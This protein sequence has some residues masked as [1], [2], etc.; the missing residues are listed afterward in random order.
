MNARVEICCKVCRIKSNKC[1]KK[2]NLRGAKGESVYKKIIIIVVM[3]IQ[4]S[5]ASLYSATIITGNSINPLESFAFPLFRFATSS[6]TGTLYVA[7]SPGQI[8]PP[9][10]GSFALAQLPLGLA[11]FVPLAPERITL[12]ITQSEQTNPFF[13][14]GI[15]ELALFEGGGFGNA[16]ELPVFVSEKEPD[17]VYVY[18][19]TNIKD[20]SVIESPLI[21]DS[22]GQPGKK[23]VGLTT[24]NSG[25][26]FSMVQPTV[27]NFGD[28]G[29]G[30]AGIIRGSVTDAQTHL[31]V[32]NQ[33]DLPTGQ[34]F[35]TPFIR[36]LPLDI[37]TSEL[38][39]GANNLAAMNTPV[40]ICWDNRIKRLFIGFS[41]TSNSAPNS[42]ACSVVVGR[43]EGNK[44]IL[45]RIAPQ[46]AFEQDALDQVV[47]VNKSGTDLFVY[48]L[49]TMVTSTNLSYLIVQG[50]NGSAE[51][52]KKSV[53]ALPLVT[54]G[55]SSVIGTIAS[56]SAVLE[57]HFVP[58]PGGVLKFSSRTVT[59]PAVDSADFARAADSPVKVGNGPIP[60]GTI[61]DLFVQSDT[62]FVCVA[63]TDPDQKAGIYYSQAL[64]DAP[65]K[66]KGWTEW[67]AVA[68][69]S[70]PVFG[71]L[72]QPTD[73]G[74]TFLT[75]S[76]TFSV[77]TVERTVW[78]QGTEN[79]FLNISEFCSQQFPLA[80]GGISTL[81][82]FVPVTP[83]LGTTSISTIGGNTG[84]MIVTTGVVN[85]TTLLPV[86]GVDYSTIPS[87]ISGKIDQQINAPSCFV[88]G[89]FFAESGPVTA[90][91]I[92]VDSVH[93][94]ATLVVGTTGGLAVLV[95]E[96]GN[97]WDATVGLGANLQGLVPGM[98]FVKR[99]KYSFVRKIIC[100]KNFLY[101]LTDSSLDRID[102]TDVSNGIAGGAPVT[103]ATVS[104]FNFVSRAAFMDLVVSDT[105]AL[106]A[107][108]QGLFRVGDG[109]S[110]R[111][112]LDFAECSWTQIPLAQ[113]LTNVTR[114]FAMSQTGRA[115]D[116]TRFNGG[117]I[118]VLNASASL[119]QAQI[120]RF[121]V[122]QK[123]EGNPV[124]PQ[125]ILPFDDVE[126]P[127]TLSPFAVFG[128]YKKDIITDGSVYFCT[129]DTNNPVVQSVSLLPKNPTPTGGHSGIGFANTPIRAISSIGTIVQPLQRN[130]ASGSWMVAGDFGLRVN[131]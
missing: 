43:L 24:N 18:E 122:A 77:N 38:L 59:P 106:L 46:E 91:E 21:N 84:I 26:V 115:Q 66:I 117:Q 96:L 1:K 116:V 74:F 78:S 129:T 107:T 65:G 5:C 14:S 81:N 120:D 15:N 27:G 16:Q 2:N 102:M 29:T 55:D 94:Q 7:A 69:T 9:E 51:N 39:I 67:Q 32:F 128:Q 101:I 33:I 104:D 103:L 118:Y 123:D 111:Q 11:G 80:K 93:N 28:I 19:S 40:S 98:R 34:V 44:M 42:G 75:G 61:T 20:I 90:T 89:G 83:G 82:S 70:L 25:H 56:T 108:T 105:F 126:I 13:Q 52:A 100:D 41:V 35:N 76:D 37:S 112:A 3:L 48:S 71:A 95:D 125:D 127:S 88:S 87:F 63:Q 6:I 86:P 62:V 110:I 36:A 50:G 73:A 85:G 10:V 92:A 4:S 58:G 17:R 72:L 130:N 60:F 124:G 53:Y 22:L 119:N 131:E 57:N 49:K 99:G 109:Q 12:N 68:G 8:N 113:S 97:G 54:Q 30:I 23:L 114:L 64:F 45:S 79:G 121:S 47:G 31:R